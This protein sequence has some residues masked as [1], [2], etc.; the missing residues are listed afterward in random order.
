MA[1]LTPSAKQQ[2]FDAN[3]NPLSGGKLYTYVAGTTTPLATYTDAGAGTPN[4]NPIILDSRGEANVWLGSSSYKLKLTTSADSELW[5]VD[6]IQSDSAKVLGDLAASGGSALV[7]FLQSGASATART[8][9]AKLRDVVSVKDFGAVGNGTTDDTAAISAACA[10]IQAAGGGV[11]YFPQGT[12]KIWPTLPG[13]PLADFSSCNN[14][15]ILGQGAKLNITYSWAGSQTQYVFKFTTCTN[16]HLELP[17]VVSAVQPVSER[18]VRGPVVAAFFTTCENIVIPLI[19]AT[20]ALAVLQW[21]G[22]YTDAVS[23]RSKNIFIG[24]GYADR[25]GYGTNYQFSGD[26]VFIG[27][28]YSN[29]PHRSYFPYGVKNH[30]VNIY[31]Q[32]QDADDCLLRSYN[33]KGLTNI[34]L[35]YTNVNSTAAQSAA[36]CVSLAPGDQTAAEFNSIEINIRANWP[37]SG[38]FGNGFHLYKNDNTGGYDPTDRGHKFNNIKLRCAFTSDYA[39]ANPLQICNEAG[40]GSGEYINGFVIESYTQ[41]GGGSSNISCASMQSSPQINNVA[42]TA[43]FY[44]NFAPS[45]AP[46]ILNNCKALNFTSA[47]SDAYYAVYQNCNITT[48]NLQSSINKTFYNTKLGALLLNDYAKSGRGLYVASKILTGDLTG[49]NN[50]F[51]VKLIASGSGAFRL[52][53]SLQDGA[54]MTVGIKS[55]CASM[56]SLGVWTSLLAVGDE[57]TQRSTGTASTVTVSLVNGTAAGAYIAVSCTNYSSASAAGSFA[58]EFM[59]TMADYVTSNQVIPA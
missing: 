11:L 35:N 16:L 45:T 1:I 43:G 50:V 12:Y 6:N 4:A 40:W 44:V 41:D 21:I 5:T 33:G 48:G 7:G 27:A 42:S 3:G 39:S 38:Y 32:D 20:G 53:Y 2:F 51:F 18:D 34:R 10:A 19:K 25:C 46:A 47:T 31:S 26:N 9:Q 15:A 49:T 13:T 8:V 36:P 57:V 17:E 24:T 52:K 37:A 14:L 58:L 22:A 30:V 28:W 56:N 55:F 29:G 23:V 59:P 54:N